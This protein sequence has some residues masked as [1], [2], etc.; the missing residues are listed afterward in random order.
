M[1][2]FNVSKEM[3]LEQALISKKYVEKMLD[4]L[5]KTPNSSEN[6]N[7]QEL[8]NIQKIH[9]KLKEFFPELFI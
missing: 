1:S 4:L 3:S 5:E 7:I 8:E 2:N 6:Q 9:N